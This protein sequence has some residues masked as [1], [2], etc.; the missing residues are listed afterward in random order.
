MQNDFE[1]KSKREQFF[2]LLN[3]LYGDVKEQD[4]KGFSLGDYDSKEVAEELGYHPS[5]LSRLLKESLHDK[6]TDETYERAIQRL[7]SVTQNRALQEECDQMKIQ[8][9]QY[10]RKEK[11]GLVAIL[12][13]G[14]IGLILSGWL[15]QRPQ[16]VTYGQLSKTQREAVMELYSELMKNELTL[17]TT[18]FFAL[19][20]EGVFGENVDYHY[21]QLKKKGNDI[22]YENRKALRATQLRAENGIYL[23][24][25]A[26]QMD[27][28]MNE[29][30]N[31]LKLA[32][33][34]SEIPVQRVVDLVMMHIKTMQ[35]DHKVQMDSIIVSQARMMRR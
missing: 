19:L 31:A 21:E 13:A 24:E 33:T 7:S 10:K 8:L 16:A 3:H 12:L 23:Y 1:P 25:L 14:L 18:L 34:N 5:Q 6:T 30:T 28:K 27:N 11:V 32:M 15:L 9:D 26:E 2:H 29:N 4:T 35:D 22:V 20:K 17:E